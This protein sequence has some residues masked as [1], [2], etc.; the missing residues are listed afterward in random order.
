MSCWCRMTVLRI[1]ASNLGFRYRRQWDAF[2]KLHQMDFDWEEEHFQV[3]LSENY[4]GAFDWG[5]SAEF[6]NPDRSLDRRDP[7]HPEIVPGP[8]LDYCLEMIEALDPED[9]TYGENNYAE[10]LSREEREAFLP[11]FQRLFP[12]FTM[13]H[14]EA[15]RYCKY[16]WYDGTDAPYLYSDY[17]VSEE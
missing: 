9:N 4:P 1:P 5:S 3:S 16:E 14:M 13:K 17:D 2:V 7:V 15:V 10:P 6:D 11:I 8:F 12:Q